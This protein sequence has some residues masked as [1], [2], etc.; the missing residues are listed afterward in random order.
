MKVLITG[1]A[2]YFGS[3]LAN[4]LLAKGH[5]VRIID[6][7]MHGGE[8]LLG[9]FPLNSFEFVFG[10]LRD[11]AARKQALEG[12][13]AVVH[14]AAIVGDPACA[15]NPQEAKEV[16]IEST[17]ALLDEAKSANVNRFVFASTCSNYGKMSDPDK[18]LT[19]DSELRPVSLYAESKVGMERYMLD[20]SLES[21][22]ILTVLRIS[23]LYGLSPR[24]RFDL[25]VN[26]FTMELITERKLLVYGEQFWRPY[27]HVR[28]ASRAVNLVLE[29]SPDKVH[30]QVFNVGDT[31]EN[32][33]KGQLVSSIVQ[34]LGGELEIQRVKKDED[35]RDYRVDFKKIKEVLGFRITRTVPDGIAEV[36]TAVRT[37][38]IRDVRDKRYRNV[39]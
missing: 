19:E 20:D 9:L 21:Q 31:R 36:A 5:Q 2:G 4:R 26:E 32:Y 17:R 10:D 3:V 27:V 18:Y 25:T 28:D 13:D 34:H 33:T 8:A 6:R 15:K 30:G 7:L 39:N 23:T 37:G 29:S 24:M 38:V 1:G 12:I 14:L 35:P 11:Q 16:N 22:T